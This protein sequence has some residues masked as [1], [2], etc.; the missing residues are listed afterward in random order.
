MTIFGQSKVGKT[1]ALSQLDD[2]LIIDTEEGTNFIDALKIQVSSLKELREVYDALASSP[3]RYKYGAIDTID[4]VVAWIEDSVVEEI[5]WERRASPGYIPAVTVG[6]VPFGSGYDRTRQKTLSLINNFKGL[7]DHLILSGHRK[8]SMIGNDVEEFS[9]NTLDLT[10]KLKHMVPSVCD[11]IGYVFRDPKD[12]SK[13][14]ISFKTTNDLEVGVRPLHLQG[15]VLDF[16]WKN[17]YID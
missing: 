10:G 16:D 9:A 13:L 2:C 17:I 12:T 11:A 6:D 1:T 3:K 14:K 7:F 8:K 4:N 5:N 15:K